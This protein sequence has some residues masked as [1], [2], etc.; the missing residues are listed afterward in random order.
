ME[1]LARSRVDPAQKAVLRLAAK[2]AG[3]YHKLIG[4]R[5]P[6]EAG[7][8]LNMKWLSQLFCHTCLFLL[9]LSAA[10]QGLSANLVQ[11]G[12]FESLGAFDL[13]PWHSL[14]GGRP[15]V[16]I[17]GGAPSVT[18]DGSN[19][20]IVVH[21]ICQDLLTVAGQCYL[22]RFAFGGNDMGQ[23]NSGP[24][25]VRWGNQEV[26]TIPISPVDLASPHWGYF[27]FVVVAESNTTRI[28]FSPRGGEAWPF[29]DD[30]Q[31]TAVPSEWMALPQSRTVEEGSTAI[32]RL[33]TISSI[34]G[35][36]CQWFF[37]GT[38]A[39]IGATNNFLRVTNTQPWQAGFYTVALSNSSLVVTSAP[40]KLN[41]IPSVKKRTVPFL[42]AWVI[43]NCARLHFECADSPI[44]PWFPLTSI[45]QTN[46]GV[47]FLDCSL[48]LPER[49]FY[50]VWTDYRSN[51]GLRITPITAIYLSG[52]VGTRLQIDSLNA[53]GPSDAW[54]PFDTVTLTNSTQLYSNE[55]MLGKIGTLYRAAPVP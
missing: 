12:S 19:F 7:L 31:V 17:L 43:C 51:P 24:L 1:L 41:I 5:G 55:R 40:A 33:K 44:G 34:Q 6:V 35:S 21:S 20:V 8:L 37:N 14:G 27:D 26:V 16:S 29:I 42:R 38:N 11:N 9:A 15:D 53:I 25:L 47:S 52:S 3:P 45:D 28:A 18:P 10:G 46:G 22:F 23:S 32:F 54:L 50:R 39:L 48:S 30:V 36:I 49:R 4:D 2:N 13:P